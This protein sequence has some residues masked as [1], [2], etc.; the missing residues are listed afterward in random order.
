M[1]R[2]FFQE[3]SDWEKQKGGLGESIINM[4]KKLK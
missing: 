3:E 1:R 2:F 4:K